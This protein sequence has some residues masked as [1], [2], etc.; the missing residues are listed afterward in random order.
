MKNAQT[1]LNFSHTIMKKLP[2]QSIKQWT[3][4]TPSS[5]KKWTEAFRR[6]CVNTKW[7]ANLAQSVST[8]TLKK[9]R[10]I[11]ESNLTDAENAHP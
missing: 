2:G 9:E 4:E 11:S 5:K 3:K 6:I 8:S 10:N 1:F 7:T